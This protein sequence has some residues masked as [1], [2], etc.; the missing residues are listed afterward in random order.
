[1]LSVLF[2][3][4]AAV[5]LI[6]MITT[7]AIP[8]RL[9]KYVAATDDNSLVMVSG[10]VIVLAKIVLSFIAA[11]VGGTFAFVLGIVWASFFGI[12]MITRA[13]SGSCLS[14]LYDLAMMTL[15]IVAVSLV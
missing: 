15:F 10:I 6:D 12:A 14:T 1:M 11:S 5:M 7:F 8:S 3:V 4:A 2:I 13:L 9:D